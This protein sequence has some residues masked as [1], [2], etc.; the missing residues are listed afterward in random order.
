MDTTNQDLDG[1]DKCLE[2]ETIQEA[3]SSE[4]ENTKILKKEKINAQRIHC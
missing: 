1:R 3:Y 4:E 2:G